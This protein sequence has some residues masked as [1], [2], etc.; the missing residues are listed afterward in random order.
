MWASADHLRHLWITQGCSHFHLD[1]LTAQLLSKGGLAIKIS[2]SPLPTLGVS[3]RNGP[4]ARK[5]VPAILCLPTTKAIL[6]E[7]QG[8]V[9]PC[10]H[11]LCLGSH[12]KAS[13]GLKSPV[14]AGESQASYLPLQLFKKPS[15]YEFSANLYPSFILCCRKK[16]CWH[17]LVFV[18]LLSS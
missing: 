3:S 11:L 16:W 10:R 1:T 6:H 18:G 15:H 7:G 5:S 14:I 17:V 9:S 13:W 8:H 2:I 4:G 12:G